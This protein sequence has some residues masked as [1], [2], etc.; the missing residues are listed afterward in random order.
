LSI[1][2][3]ELY[4]HKKSINV[5]KAKNSEEQIYLILMVCTLHSVTKIIIKITYIHG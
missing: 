2:G 4:A 1:V 5:G 3:S